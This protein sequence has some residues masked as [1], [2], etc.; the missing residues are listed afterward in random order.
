MV[1]D[2][3]DNDGFE[4]FDPLEDQGADTSDADQA[5]KDA[6]SQNDPNDPFAS[7]DNL[8]DPF[9]GDD[10]FGIETDDDFMGM[11]ESGDPFADD[12]AFSG[13]AF[14][15]ELAA[16]DEPEAVDE[17][18]AQAIEEGEAI[19]DSYP[20]DDGF[21][22][23]G[24]ADDFGDF[25]EDDFGDD[26]Y[27]QDDLEGLGDANPV[28]AGGSGGKEF[29]KK[30]FQYIAFGAIGI[31]GA[32]LVY[33]TLF[34]QG[35]GG[36]QQQPMQ[37]ANNQQQMQM[38]QNQQSAPSNND[39]LGN[40]ER[41]ADSQPNQGLL[42]GGERPSLGAADKQD[43][44][45]ALNQ[46]Q[47]PAQPDPTARV[48]DQKTWQQ[49]PMPSP[50]SKDGQ[51]QAQQMPTKRGQD[52][53]VSALEQAEQRLAR[54]GSG[55]DQPAIPSLS[56]T[57][58]IPATG[59]SRSN[60]TEALSQGESQRPDYL[61]K[62]ADDIASSGVSPSRSEEEGTTQQV[63]APVEDVSR[64]NAFSRTRQMEQSESA[65]TAPEKQTAQRTTSTEDR[66]VQSTGMTAQEV[67]NIRAEMSE[68]FEA[69]MAELENKLS[70]MSGQYE[71]LTS[72]IDSMN[73]RV[74][75][76]V[77]NADST[78]SSNAQSGSNIDQFEANIARL[79]QKIERLEESANST[80]IRRAPAR[81]NRTQ[82]R[83][84]RRTAPAS[85][86]TKRYAPSSARVDLPS[87]KPSLGQAVATQRPVQTTGVTMADAIG[88]S[89]TPASSVDWV[90]RAA[91][92]GVAWISKGFDA[93]IK[94]VFVGQTLAN[95]G[96]IQSISMANGTW[97][98]QGSQG[99]IV[100]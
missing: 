37:L 27:A 86:P 68:A 56:A 38:G 32:Y 51:D 13:D 14:D 73:A 58:E 61:T 75:G 45:A 34:P 97:E 72:K 93:P 16:I 57:K 54:S 85:T 10:D 84:V 12:D 33:S 62:T 19:G 17:E 65:Q 40:V 39:P 55:Q 90:L 8:D 3:K 79:E 41:Q 60:D 4:E 81:D 29:L 35:L 7:D 82:Q 46:P 49:P 91:Q 83:D 78:P 98:V 42:M 26:P 77:N 63:A 2:N 18:K 20:D 99:R 30:N 69:K 96:T 22:D 5:S 70:A 25:S 88:R 23:L 64:D 47:T 66:N 31:V 80:A 92:P 11:E 15:D 74:E 1:T 53:K 52:R 71:A 50:I 87:Q 95:V 9:A 94:K 44:T 21:D 76:L 28:S 48:T 24:A 43:T 67:S 59:S 89:Q 36:G 6:A 100:Q